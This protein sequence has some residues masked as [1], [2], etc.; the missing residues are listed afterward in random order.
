MMPSH[1]DLSVIIPLFNEEESIEPLYAKLIAALSSLHKSYEIIFVNDGSSDR[2]YEIL[3]QLAGRDK[4]IKLI[5]FRRNFGQTAAMSAGFDH[6]SGKIIIPMDADLQN[7]PADI[8][9]LLAKLDEGYD[10]AS[11]WR[12]ERQDK[13]PMRIVTSKIANWIIGLFT[14]VKLHD[15]GCSL[16]AYRAEMLQG[17]RLYGEMHRFIPALAN[18]MGARICEVPVSHHPR[19]YGK[20]KYGFKRILKVLLDLIT[21]KFLA[22]FST[23]PLYMFGGIGVGLFIGAVLAGAETLWERYSPTARSSTTI[24]SSCSPFSSRVSA[25]ISS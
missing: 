19:A 17:T 3:S 22:D 24:L 5:Q 9:L 15:S 12:K 1:L 21:V 18:L 14:G 8:H 23:K 13:E 16:K 7:D 25:S 6:A 2:S 11:G 20:S 4:N 10:V